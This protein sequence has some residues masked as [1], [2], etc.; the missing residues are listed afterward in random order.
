MCD[1]AVLELFIDDTKLEE[2]KNKRVLEVGSKY[3]NGSVRPLIEKFFSPK[4]YIGVDVESGKFVDLILPAEKILDRFG[5]ES[6]DFVISTELL[7]HVVDWRLVVRNM[8]EVL[9]HGGYIYV[10]TRSKGFG[11]HA[12]PYDFW[13]YEVEDMRRIFAD[14]EIAVLKKDHEAPGVFLKARKPEN[15]A[16]IDLSDIA[17]YSMVLGRRVRDISSV[18]NMPFTRA[19]TIRLLHSKAGSLMP[20]ALLVRLERL[21]LC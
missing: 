1:V 4:E 21:C 7:E 16:P 14:F 17:L 10:T 3:V 13:R 6:F 9:K 8:K 5:S 18:K 12:Y 2:F 20:R 19:L 15:Y 11:Y